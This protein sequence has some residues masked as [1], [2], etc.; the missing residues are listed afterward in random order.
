M[1]HLYFYWIILQNQNEMLVDVLRKY[2]YLMISLD[3]HLQNSSNQSIYLSWCHADAFFCPTYLSWCYTDAFWSNFF[4]DA[5]C[6]KQP[7]LICTFLSS[8]FIA[9]N[10]NLW[11]FSSLFWYISKFSSSFHR[12]KCLFLIFTVY[13]FL[14]S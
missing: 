9:L 11:T 14:S 3:F 5:L 7:S 12:M 10:A 13:S 8:T 6:L 4:A 2:W 1:W